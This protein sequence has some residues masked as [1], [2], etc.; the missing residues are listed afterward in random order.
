M[1]GRKK[2]NARREQHRWVDKEGFFLAGYTGRHKGTTVGLLPRP[3][4]GAAI[5]EKN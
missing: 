4:V 5:G 3:T 2:L 1:K